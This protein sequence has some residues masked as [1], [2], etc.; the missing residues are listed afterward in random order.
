MLLLWVGW[1]LVIVSELWW[2]SL[3]LWR[4]VWWSLVTVVVVPVVMMPAVAK[5]CN[6]HTHSH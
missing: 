3:Q 6:R 4:R 1:L 5:S 2:S